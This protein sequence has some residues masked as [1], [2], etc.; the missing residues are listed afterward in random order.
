MTEGPVKHRVLEIYSDHSDMVCG[1]VSTADEPLEY[2]TLDHDTTCPA[3]LAVQRGC[4]EE[5]HGRLAIA[6]RPNEARRFA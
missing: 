1:A 6:F 2:V 3:C 5:A 4:A